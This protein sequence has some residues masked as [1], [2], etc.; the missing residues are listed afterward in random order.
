MEKYKLLWLALENIEYGSLRVSLPGGEIK[1]F[2]SKKEGPKAD[3]IIND[4]QALDL[5]IHGGDVGFGETYIKGLWQTSNLTTLLTFFSYNSDAL[6]HYFHAKKLKS[7]ILFFITLFHKNSKKGSKKNISFHYDLGNNFYKLWLDE[8]MTYSSA[9]FNGKELSLEK[10]QHNKYKN[11]L[12]KLEGKNILEIGCGWGG[13][14]YEAAKKK[15]DVTCLTLSQRQ[16]EYALNKIRYN[17]LDDKVNIKLQDYR[18]EKG[19]YDNIVS[20]EMFEA[21]GQQY[22]DKYFKVLSSCLK[23]GGKAVLQIITI[24]EEVFYHYKKRVDFIQKHIFPG[25]ALP[26]KTILRDLAQK[27]NLKVVSELSFGK[28]YAKTLD[29]WLK[30]FDSKEKEIRA[31]GFGKEFIRKWRFYLAYCIAGFLAQRTDVIQL[32]LSS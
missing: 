24:D 9:L 5:S 1:E 11:I 19:L 3:I 25:G 26:S 17:N 6:E 28:D 18:D 4:L 7:F 10:A 20:I 15:F 22:W 32:E 2:D 27:N 16:Q 8:S 23:K 13:F 14:A 29:M 12:D 21:V 31:Q 30:N